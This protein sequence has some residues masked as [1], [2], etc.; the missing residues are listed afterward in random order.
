MLVERAHVPE[1]LMYPSL[2]NADGC[3]LGTWTRQILLS[4]SLHV[5][6][7]TQ[8]SSMTRTNELEVRRLRPSLYSTLAPRPI[9]TMGHGNSNKLYVTHA[10]HS[11]MFGQHTASSAGFKV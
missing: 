11:G 3:E 6:H 7:V 1:D 10:E 4:L 8:G 2:E 9:I 5:G